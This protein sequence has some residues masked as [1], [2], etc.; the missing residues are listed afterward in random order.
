MHD[1]GACMDGYGMDGACMDGYGMDG[2][3][4]DGYGMEG[5]LHG[6]LWHGGRIPY[7]V[8]ATDDMRQR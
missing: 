5:A 4:M 3:C 6:W 7:S 8:E 2:A 1:D